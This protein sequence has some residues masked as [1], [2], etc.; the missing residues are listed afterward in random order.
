M[1]KT[2]SL[3]PECIEQASKK[4]DHLGEFI[5]AKMEKMR[6]MSEP[7]FEGEATT[8]VIS[9]VE[10]EEDSGPHRRS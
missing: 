2:T 3:R 4:L 8:G 9:P 7:D 1:A 6:R 5:D 10:P